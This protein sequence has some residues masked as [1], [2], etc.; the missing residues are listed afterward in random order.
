MI[1]IEKINIIYNK[2]KFI[3]TE[4]ADVIYAADIKTA[5]DI[6]KNYNLKYVKNAHGSSV[7]ESITTGSIKIDSNN[8]IQY[9]KN[10]NFNTCKEYGNF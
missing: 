5:R 3:N 7:F 4:R 8:Y 2:N 6:I 10:I 9:Y 1:R